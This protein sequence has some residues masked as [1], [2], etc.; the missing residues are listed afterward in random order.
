MSWRSIQYICIIHHNYDIIRPRFTTPSNIIIIYCT[1]SGTNCNQDKINTSNHYENRIGK[2]HIVVVVDI[3]KYY[4]YYVSS[5]S[6][7][8]YT[9]LRAKVLSALLILINVTKVFKIFIFFIIYIV[10]NC[11]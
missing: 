9:L 7:V 11:V 4:Y 5:Y 10:I 1:F 8:K 6:K 3:I 2:T